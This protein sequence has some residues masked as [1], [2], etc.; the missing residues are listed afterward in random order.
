M[1]FRDE[2]IEKI[3]KLYEDHVV[4]RKAIESDWSRI[5]GY[6]TS[7]LD[8]IKD[9]REFACAKTEE[10]ETELMLSVE[11]HE[12]SFR[13]NTDTIKVFIDGEVL[14]DL[15]PTMDGYCINFKEEKVLE[16]MD[17]YM[18]LAFRGVLTELQ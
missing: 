13:K 5:R 11:G 12:L 16:R 9:V 14:E 15:Y 2:F 18:G 7:F 4:K 10:A 8:E 1:S 17:I 3:N 6:M